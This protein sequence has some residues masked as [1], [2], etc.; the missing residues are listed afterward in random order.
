MR[1]EWKKAPD[2]AEYAEAL[3]I[4]TTSILA[5]GG[6]ENDDVL[7]LYS[8]DEDKPELIFGVSL[9]RGQDGILAPTGLPLEQPGLWERIVK[10]LES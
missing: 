3:G 1:A 10:E 8:P 7:V 2:F 5:L 4:P 9:R 6:V